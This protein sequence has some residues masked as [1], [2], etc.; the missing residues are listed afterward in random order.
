MNDALVSLV[1]QH[2]TI[3]A[4]LVGF[5]LF[6]NLC[7]LLVRWLPSYGQADDQ[8]SAHWYA[9][10]LKF[11]SNVALNPASA[12]PWLGTDRRNGG[13]QNGSN[14]AQAPGK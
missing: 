11:L 9:V 14:G 10:L 7:A 13:G 5:S 4:V 3:T 12:V 8:I 6:S 2:P 1:Q